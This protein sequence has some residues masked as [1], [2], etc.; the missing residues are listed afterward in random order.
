MRPPK[1]PMIAP[2]P[3]AA[4][5]FR[6]VTTEKM[7]WCAKLDLPVIRRGGALHTCLRQGVGLKNRLV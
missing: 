2:E 3:N 4:E 6:M 5:L 1:V 7:R